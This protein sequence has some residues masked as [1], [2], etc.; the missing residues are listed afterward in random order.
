MKIKIIS[1][2]LFFLLAISSLAI[3]GADTMVF[4]NNYVKQTPI[5][6]IQAN[7]NGPS[8]RPASTVKI[9]LAESLAIINDGTSQ[10]QG[11]QNEPTTTITTRQ[12]INLSENLAITTDP[13]Y[14]NLIAV[15]KQNSERNSIMERIWNNDKV[16]FNGR[17]IITNDDLWNEQT[18]IDKSNLDVKQFLQQLSITDKNNI[19]ISSLDKIL[20]LQP[21]VTN[22]QN[23]YDVATFFEISNPA[24]I[25]FI[26]LVH[27]LTD[28]KNP[29]ILLLLVP[30]SGYVLFRS[31]EEKLR[32]KSKQVLSFCF[33]VILVSSAVVTP[34]SVSPAFLGIVYAQTMNDTSVTNNAK[35]N[36]T[37][38]I[39]STGNAIPTGPPRKT[40]NDTLQVAI[41]S[42]IPINSTHT[43][44]PTNSKSSLL[45]QISIT[46]KITV[47]TGSSPV[48]PI[49][50]STHTTVP[51][52]STKPSLLDQFSMTD[53]ITINYTN[54]SK[55]PHA[56]KSWQFN[57][58]QNVT[59]VGSAKIQNNT[60]VT[61]LKLV[62]TGYLK[63]QLNLTRNLSALT[64]SAWVKPDY[65]QGSPQF[66]I[67][68]KEK[69]FILSI[70]NV[71]PPIKIATFSVFDGIKWSTVNSTV[72]IQ[73][74]WTHLAATFNGSSISIYVNGTL[75]STMHITGVP[76]LSVNGQLTTKTVDQISSN[77]D[78]VIGAYL[79]TLRGSPSNQ[80]SGLIKNVNLYDTVLSQL[81]IAQLYNIP[82]SH[83]S[84]TSKISNPTLS[85]QI[86][87]TDAVT[88]SLSLLNATSTTP[89]NA[90][91]SSNVTITPELKAVKKGY[92]ITET[93]QLEF[94]Y[95]ND[96]DILKNAKK[97]I[98]DQLTKID[99]V[100]QN[101]NKTKT[102]INSTSNELTSKTIKQINQ[103]QQQID[104][105]QE[106][107]KKTQQSI[108]VAE[109]TGSPQQIQ[110]A[111]N[112]T[113]A[114]QK[115]VKGISILL[116]DTGDQIKQTAQQVS[117]INN[118]TSSAQ[119][120]ATVGAELNSTQQTQS[121]K[122]T[123]SK[124]TITV[125][126]TG[127]DGK[128]INAQPQIEQ[129]V[130]GKFNIKI[131]STRDVTP[132][133]YKVETTL[134]K[135]GKTYTTYDTYQWGLVSLN[136]K[137][138]T[139]KLGE[140]AD[141]I[142]VVLDNGGHPVC[143]SNIVTNIIDPVK[144][145]TVL[146]SGHG[147]TPN[148]QCG[149]YDAQYVTTTEG[150]YTVNVTAQNPSGVANF[151]TTFLVQQN[152]IFDIIRTAESKIDPTKSNLFNV[153]IDV[154]SY[155]NQKT[156]QIQEFVPSVFTVTTDANVQ[157]IGDTKVLT[158][159]KD[160]IGNKTFVQYSYSVPLEFPRLYALGPLEI[161]YDGNQTF[162][163]ARPWFVANDP[164]AIAFV[165]AANNSGSA[166]PIAVTKTVTARNTVVVAI[167]ETPATVAVTSITGGGTYTQQGTFTNGVTKVELWSTTAGG[168]TAASSVSVAF[169]GTADQVAVGVSEYS[170]VVALGTTATNSGVTANP[171]ISKTTVDNN[172]WIVS[173]LGGSSGSTE[174]A[175]TALTGNLRTAVGTII[176]N[177]NDVALGIVDN[178]AATPSSVTTSETHAADTWAAVALELRLGKLQTLA[179]T[180]TSSDTITKS[181]KKQL[182]ETLT[183]SDTV[184]T[185][186][187]KKASLSET[188]TSSD[189]VSTRS[190]KTQSLSE[191][192]TL[193]DAI[194]TKKGKTQSLSESLTTSDTLST[195]A[196]RNVLVT[197]I[198]FQNIQSVSGTGSTITLPSFS[199]SSD[200]NRYL[201]VGVETD[202][203][204]VTSVTYGGVNLGLI[205]AKLNS[206][207]TEFWGLA[208]P[209]SGSGNI[210]VNLSGSG[211]V[212]VGAYNIIGVDQTT[213]IVA[214]ATASSALGGG[215]PTISISNTYASSVV[216]DSAAKLLTTITS[217]QMQQWSIIVGSAVSGGS[218][219][220][221]PLSPRSTTFTW[222]P[223][224]DPG[225]W[226]EVA[227]EVKAAGLIPPA[228][229]IQITDTVSTSAGKK[230]SLSETLT[231]SDTV[232]TSAGKKQS[233]SETL[234]S[235]DTV[236]T[237]AGKKQSLSETLTSSDTL[238]R[239]AVLSRSFA[240]SLG[241]TDSLINTSGLQR[242]VDNSETQITVESNHPQLVV[243]SCNATLSTITV[244][245][246]VSTA[247]LNYSKIVQTSGSSHTVQ[248]C[249]AL[250]I[251]KDTTGNSISDI[252]VII[253]AAINMTGPTSWNGAVNL[254]TVQATSSVP[255][256]AQAGVTN[257]VTKSIEVGFGSTTLTLN[258][259]A[260]IVFVGAA[261]QHVGYYNSVIPF[262]EI[263]TTCSDNTQITNNGLPSGGN[264]K[265]NVGSDLVVWTKHFTGFATFSS[266]SSSAPAA[267]AAPASG[268]TGAAAGAV[269]VGPSGAG[270]GTTGGFGGI[271]V[272]YLK[273]HQVSYDVCNQNIVR[274]IVGT[275]N[276][277]NPS[278]ILR[279]SISGV[280]GAQLAKEQPYEQQNVNA[281]V[282]KLVYEA[283]INPKEKSFEVLALEAVGHN[284]Y[285]TGKTIEITGCQETIDFV[286]VGLQPQP[287]QVD[288]TAPKIFDVKLQLGNGTK[289]L[290]SDATSYADKQ[291][292]SV[293]AIIDSPA[294]IDRAELRFVKL[295][296]DLEKYAAVK[297]D[298][299]PLQASNTTY[300]VSGTIP[301]GSMQS[302]ATQYWLDV[303]NNAG[304]TTD[305]EIYTIGVKTSY[306]INGKLELDIVHNRAAGTTSRPTAYFT[307]EANIPVY[308]TISL[309]VDGESVYTSPGQLFKAGQT[310]I[311]L[312]WKT[313]PTDQL[314][315]HNIQ[316]VANVYDKSFTAQ[317]TIATFSATKTVSISAPI[318]IE[319]I[320]DNS[321]HTIANPQILYSSFNNEGNM[322]FKV[323]APDGTC[324][325][326]GSNNCLVT[327]STFGL[328]GQ[329]K[330]IT[331]GDQIYRVR[332][333][334]TD[335][336]LERFSITSVDPIVG[337]WN[338]EIDSKQELLPMAHAMQD[339]FLKITFRPVETPFVTETK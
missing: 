237:S 245:S 166:T 59:A 231:S 267:A 21:V 252:Q 100:E 259:A 263:T 85:D 112:Q 106:Q 256:P 317:A 178:T 83:Q 101:L 269:G 77:A 273:I 239:K 124:E 200:S 299:I 187:S 283:H 148:S 179:E 249:N 28:T 38:P 226:A 3:A 278:V 15:V 127:P 232:S 68:S 206:V 20:F 73:E 89:T 31:E 270:T 151:D 139:Y 122:W 294:S 328:P 211:N 195:S 194:S 19:M 165:S 213:P 55:I 296:G 5:D 193:S 281:T 233:L 303:K 84:T 23:V 257:T 332:Y 339:V 111:L 48:G 143:N 326:G 244:P 60:N 117:T 330:S 40:S 58:T 71:I 260:R 250:T 92:L 156:V 309:I 209:A 81:Q 130:D 10:P 210:V 72:P 78:I 302:P 277:V 331:V 109:K 141:F 240:E 168:A 154:S 286:H 335:S 298:V 120:I 125:K 88:V 241:L 221:V 95:L 108:A 103:A 41:N 201:L 333:S 280:V 74:N 153:R 225:R 315:N 155:V 80:F 207:D 234:T 228:E 183:S 57:S 314:T 145:A 25:K 86:G 22:I 217:N 218:S 308:G 255:L 175:P 29:T 254:P 135:D 320:T 188:L 301:Q 290:A 191:S 219:S 251:N 300:I 11:K 171:T 274:I 67:I 142:I 173:G 93:P 63:Q 138:S 30:L 132:G 149:L 6:K 180:L 258:K 164:F 202:G 36:V 172:N 44:V 262:T 87:F 312:E 140:T 97:E 46:D 1:L 47:N 205:V 304:K 293:F 91:T 98:K 119:D 227:L 12:Q 65:S 311:R 238:S 121:G 198:V 39:Q 223:G 56:I 110:E 184:S 196:N 199:V 305:S 216:I 51:T 288:L 264:C 45:D 70:N 61:S 327:G 297:M 292:M 214:T 152:S 54:I 266:S 52:N 284:V 113:I 337:Q 329:V 82:S 295:G 16:R 128:P 66:T 203:V 176:G 310:P 222:T 133:I 323:V 129:M 279:T 182:S 160:L 17:S 94:H 34:I 14:Q 136:T 186:A 181:I 224:S 37:L 35:N 144:H 318:K 322:R 79:N 319:S 90:T 316:A 102:L 336:P 49:T 313:Q 275:D 212:I 118:L 242:F 126:V 276:T 137:K 321:G 69:Q 158:W 9:N 197:S 285:S 306:S 189:T 289:V 230:Q 26:G 2:F 53:K 261:G 43:T 157:T 62:G 248:V 177:N 99:K 150:N 192:L 208:A 247:M 75:Q 134:L 185:T 18:S 159:N 163:E 169:S 27:D 107:I 104:T 334:G 4:N 105:V 96:S 265:I 170:G 246:T 8:P 325:I 243:L 167:V 324:V 220:A 42:I 215:P 282:R 161:K 116:K 162:R 13:Q 146:S 50:N 253:P 271:L 131:S 7:F 147:I 338:T 235:S 64:L 236:S 24:K 229:R 307:N 174:T 287:T 190:G 114:T 76:A 33:I 32:F 272:P 204:T 291:S 268:G 115:Q 123:N